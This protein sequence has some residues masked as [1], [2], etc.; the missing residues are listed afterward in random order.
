MESPSLVDLA[1]ALGGCSEAIG[2]DEVSTRSDERINVCCRGQ[3]GH[4]GYKRQ[5][6][7]ERVF[8]TSFFAV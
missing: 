8:C 5:F 1:V 2:I 7:F 3:E 4:P 6:H